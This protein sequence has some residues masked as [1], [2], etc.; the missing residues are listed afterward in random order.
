[1]SGA[2]PFG[3]Y[4]Y[5]LPA[6]DEPP[7]RYWVDMIVAAP[8]RI[9]EPC[10]HTWRNGKNAIVAAE[11]VWTCQPSGYEVPLCGTCVYWWRQNAAADPTLAPARIRS[12]A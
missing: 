3:E 1:M 8:P 7:R 12:I 4:Q 11:Y 2:L 9:C 5:W 10:S 6:P